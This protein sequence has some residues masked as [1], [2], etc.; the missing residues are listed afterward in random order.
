[1]TKSTVIFDG[2]NKQINTILLARQRET[3]TNIRLNVSLW[4]LLLLIKL[5]LKKKK[6][7][8]KI[9]F[10]LEMWKSFLF[11]KY[12]ILSFEILNTLVKYF[13]KVN[14]TLKKQKHTHFSIFFL[15]NYVIIW[16]GR[17]KYT[18]LPSHQNSWYL[19]K[20]CT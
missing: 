14:S 9:W 19:T 5:G 11:F 15:N 8:I 17:E 16:S 1:M 13:L 18:G 4:T 7:K 3:H 12:F 6:I 20:L 10:P 2:I